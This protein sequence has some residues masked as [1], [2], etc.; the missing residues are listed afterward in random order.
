MQKNLLIIS[1]KT[2]VIVFATTPLKIIFHID[3]HN[4]VEEK[5]YTI[6]GKSKKK[7]YFNLLLF[8]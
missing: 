7:Y 1:K 5:D 4:H 6:V 2:F 8:R 3:I